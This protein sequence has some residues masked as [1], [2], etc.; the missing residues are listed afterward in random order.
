[1]R[2]SAYLNIPASSWGQEKRFEASRG[3]IPE[4]LAR[5]SCRSNPQIK[6][7]SENGG[8]VQA[9][10]PAMSPNLAASSA[11]RTRPPNRCWWSRESGGARRS[12]ERS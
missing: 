2:P 7:R 12:A 10:V 5:R 4:K 3:T 1:M 9:G 8:G 6:K 11:L